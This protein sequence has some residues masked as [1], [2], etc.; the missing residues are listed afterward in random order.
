MILQSYSDDMNLN[1]ETK[2]TMVRFGN[3][4]GSSGSPPLFQKQIK[5]GG[6]VTVTHPDVT[7]YLY[8]WGLNWSF[9]LEQWRREMY[10]F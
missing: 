6:R 1:N 10:L 8:S 4:L 3:V 9:K 7:R 2:M 5:D